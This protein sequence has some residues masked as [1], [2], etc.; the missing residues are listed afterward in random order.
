MRSPAA[1]ARREGACPAAAIGRRS[2]PADRP[3][4]R[5]PPPP[6]RTPPRTRARAPPREK[7]AAADSTATRWSRRRAD[8]GGAPRRRAA[9]RPRRSAPPRTRPRPR[10]ARATAAGSLVL[11]L[12]QE[13]ADRGDVRA[14]AQRRLAAPIHLGALAVEP[15][16]QLARR[17][18]RRS[19]GEV[20]RLA[21][22]AGRGEEAA[23]RRP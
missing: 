20:D 4:S 5:P 1:A 15:F 21:R 11:L 2:S 10:R 16:D 19:G 7:P 13:V 3:A 9:C 12:R 17:L 18:R 22:V 6:P 14:H 8:P 23:P